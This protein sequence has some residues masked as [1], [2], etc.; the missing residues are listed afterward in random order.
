MYVMHNPFGQMLYEHVYWAAVFVSSV[1]FSQR[2]DG[3]FTLRETQLCSLQPTTQQNSPTIV[4]V[5]KV[6]FLYLSVLKSSKGDDHH[7]AA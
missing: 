2:M 3:Y 7:D 5:D 6:G 4:G 1:L